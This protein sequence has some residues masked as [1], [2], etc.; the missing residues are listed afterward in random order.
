MD[1]QAHDTSSEAAP[2]VAHQPS[3]GLQIVHH[4]GQCPTYSSDMVHAIAVNHM[5]SGLRSADT[6]QYTKPHCH[7]EIGKRAF[8][9]A[10]PLAW[11]NLPLSLH[12]IN[13]SKRFRKHLKRI[14]LIILS[15]THCNAC[16]ENNALLC[17]S[18]GHEF[19]SQ[20]RQ[21]F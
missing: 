16:L 9:Y 10:G 12:C 7:T 11:N 18:K 4:T 15:S 5:R 14:I 3:S 21:H 13:D 6:A 2:L 8:S 19:A 1:E 17:N 20:L